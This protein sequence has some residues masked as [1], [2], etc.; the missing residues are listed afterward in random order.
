MHRI[1]RRRQTKRSSPLVSSFSTPL[2]QSPNLSP[3]LLSLRFDSSGSRRSAVS[4]FISRISL[5][6]MFP[7][8]FVGFV[9]QSALL[10]SSRPFICIA[11]ATPSLLECS[12]DEWCT[13]L[14]FQIWK[15]HQSLLIYPLL[16][17]FIY[18]KYFIGT[19][20]CCSCFGSSKIAL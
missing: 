20:Y 5:S 14:N 17:L 9:R 11:S 10:S 12:G 13:T 19:H 8:S 7:T 1:R 15:M 6:L 2:F 4:S 3:L 16:L 18:H